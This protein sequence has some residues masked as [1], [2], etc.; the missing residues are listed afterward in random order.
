VKEGQAITAASV[1]SEIADLEALIEARPARASTLR[2]LVVELR[3]RQA[4]SRLSIVWMN[5]FEAAH[6]THG[7]R[8]SRRA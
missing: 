4:T 3:T 6:P 1:A 2:P 5:L 7:E 8:R